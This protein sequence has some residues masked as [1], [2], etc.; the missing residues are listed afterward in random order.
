MVPLL[1]NSGVL[2]TLGQAHVAAYG[3][4][5]FLTL[6]GASCA[7]GAGAATI[8]INSDANATQAGGIAGSA[9]LIAYHALKNPTFFRTSFTPAIALASMLLYGF[10]F[11]DNAALGGFSGGYLMFLFA[12]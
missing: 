1:F 11:K 10:Y 8:G 9:G 3:L 2:L 6:Y 7:A 4:N 12:L 5:S